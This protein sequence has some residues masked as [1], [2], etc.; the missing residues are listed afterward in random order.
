MHDQ[1]LQWCL[2]LQPYGPYPTRLLCPWGFPGK[3]TGEGFHFLLQGIFPTQRL[4]PCLLHLLHWQAGSLSL[5]PPGKPSTTLRPHK[6]KEPALAALWVHL[7][8]GQGNVPTKSR[9]SPSRT[10][11]GPQNPGSVWAF[12]RADL[13]TDLR[14]GK[15][16]AACRETRQSVGMV[17]SLS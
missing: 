6:S 16:A 15:G 2:T 9:A 5:M 4:N 7:S 8:T 1:V 13:T 11:L 10:C 3:N 14:G 12:P 17:Y